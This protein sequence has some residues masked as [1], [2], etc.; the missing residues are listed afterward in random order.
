MKSLLDFNDLSDIEWNHLLSLA[1]QIKQ[2]PADFATLCRGKVMATLFYEPSTRTQFSFQ[3]AM[4]RLGGTIIGFSDPN[5]T[6]VS[7]GETLIDTTKIVSAYAD[8]IAM[9]HPVEGAPY[10]ASL[11]APIP[12]INAGDG[13]HLHPTQTLTDLYTISDLKGTLTGLNIGI[14]GDLKNG[15]TVHSLLKAFM[16]FPGNEFYLISHPDLAVPQYVLKLLDRAGVHY[17]QITSLDECIAKLDV[18]YMTRVQRERFA[19]LA[20]YERLAGCYTLDMAKMNVAKKDLAVLHP[21]PKIDEIAYEVDSD[22]RALY[23]T[24]AKNGMYI[25][26]ALIATLLDSYEP[27]VM[28]Q[29]EFPDRVCHNPRCITRHET[30]L[31]QLIRQGKTAAY[32]RYCEHETDDKQ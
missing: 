21:L 1:R 26:M 17:R 3:T 2:S 15:R 31:P 18:L 24:Q 19:S 29:N 28:P 22:P 16:R 10:A 7:K 13:G 11:F 23:F 5:S 25:R 14:C 8:I 4:Q 32:C 6:S 12:V 27:S 20:K 30:Y 9:R